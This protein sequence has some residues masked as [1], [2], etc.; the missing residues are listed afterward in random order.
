MRVPQLRRHSSGNARVTLNGKD[1][2]LGKFGSPEATQAYHQIMAEWEASGRSPA[3]R[4]NPN[5]ITVLEVIN[6]YGSFA[7][8]YYG[9]GP[10]SELLRVKP[11]LDCLKNLYGNLHACDFGPIQFKALRSELMKPSV[12]VK[13]DSS[14]IERPRS[15]EYVN[16]LMKFIRRVFKWAASESLVSSSIYS[17]LS[18]VMPLRFGKTTAHENEKVKPA[19]AASVEKTTP[20]LS[21]VVKA[22]V[23]FQQLTGCRPGEVCALKPNMVDRSTDV[24]EVHLDKHKTA[25]RG[26]KRVIFVGP[27]GQAILAPYLLRDPDANCFSPRESERLRREE[28]TANRV[29][30]LS[31]G[32]RPGSNRKKSPGRLP[33]VC[34]TTQ[35]YDRAVKYACEKA[36]PLPEGLNEAE[37]KKWK[38]DHHWAPNQLRHSMATLVRKS[39]GKNGLEAASVLL[40]HSEL[41]V[42]QIYAEADRELAIEVIRK[43]G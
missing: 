11:A 13:K 10:N 35:S 2:L 31:C 1:F 14:T 3:F 21:P 30:P 12:F 27:K 25:W 6:A 22:M 4:T 41:E 32:N 37:E 43:I 20:F 17:D 26:K 24:W 15:R 16:R 40:G 8:E 28:A 18:T 36:F 5:Q 39:E 34:Y 38:K 42:T 33:S 29:V 9:D 23:Q 19:D 7:K